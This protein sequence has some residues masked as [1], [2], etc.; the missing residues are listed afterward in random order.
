MLFMDPHQESL[1]GV[2]CFHSWR[3]VNMESKL[4]AR[5]EPQH[6]RADFFGF[7]GSRIKGMAQ[8]LEVVG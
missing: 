4:A 8:M 3:G 7:S 1:Q 5:W 2:R 6:S